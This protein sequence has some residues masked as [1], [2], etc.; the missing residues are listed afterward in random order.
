M[1]TDYIIA[2]AG[3]A[4]VTLAWEL[5]K[6][7]L[8]TVIFDPMPENTSSQ[9]AAGLINPVVPRRVIPAWRAETIFEHIPDYYQ[10]I[11]RFTGSEVYT[12]YR[13]YQIH[14]SAAENEMWEAQSRTELM[15]PFIRRDSLPEE[16]GLQAANGCSQILMCGRVRVS[17]L[18]RSVSEKW[19]EN[20]EFVAEKIHYPDIILKDNSVEYR[21]L[22]ARGIIFC[23]GAAS[24]G[25]PWFGNLPV[26]NTPGDIV[27]LKCMSLPQNYILKKKYWLIPEGDHQFSAGSTFIHPK[28]L[29]E[30]DKLLNEMLEALR[31][32]L[33]EFEVIKTLRAGRPTSPDR[34]P[35]CG[36]HGTHPQLYIYN[37][38]GSRGCSIVTWLSAEM[39]DFVVHNRSLRPEV[40]FQRFG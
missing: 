7:G 16:T 28:M 18:I 10:S 31:N 3:I 17:E 35:I 11:A 29:N 34:R 8:K 6:K 39:A 36:R 27:L 24:V 23:E 15:K 14:S 20:N 32:W 1:E 33:P 9:I 38:L 19:K 12:P 26:Q 40:Q 21:G 4:G 30:P 2:G 13:F 25:N 5:R 22:K 37:G